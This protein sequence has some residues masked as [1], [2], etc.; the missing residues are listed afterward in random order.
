MAKYVRKAKTE[1]KKMLSIAQVAEQLD[2][3]TRTVHRYITAGRLR[4]YKVAPRVIR[5]DPDDV[6][7]QL[8][9]QR[10]PYTS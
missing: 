7:A 6:A 10:A 3:S 9:N 2:L 8:L 4:A 1:Q 5:I